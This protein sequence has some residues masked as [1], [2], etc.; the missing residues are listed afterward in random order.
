MNRILKAPEGL[1][2]YLG[3]RDSGKL[4]WRTTFSVIWWLTGGLEA[5]Y[6]QIETARDRTGCRTKIP[7][8]ETARNY[9]KAM[10]G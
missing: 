5:P 4:K 8:A 10:F 6:F 2:K 9:G 3:A 1:E 7:R